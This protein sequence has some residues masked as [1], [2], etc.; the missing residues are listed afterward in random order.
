MLDLVFGVAVA[1]GFALALA[2]REFQRRLLASAPPSRP[3]ELSAVSIL[4]PLK[5][6]DENLAQNLTS[7]FNLE[8]PDYELLFGVA[9]AEDPALPIVR[10]LIEQ[11][12]DIAAEVVVDSRE[13]GINPKVNNLANL[14]RRARHDILLISDSNVVV[15]KGYLT[16]LVANLERPGVGMVSSP[17][18]GV[19]GQGL[20]GALEALQLNT[21]VMG[22][23][24][25]V[26]NFRLPC[27]VEKSMLFRRIHLRAVG[28]FEFLGQF[29]AEDQVFA[30]E[31]H[32]RQM[33]I[34]VSGVPV[35]NV[36]GPLTVLDFARRHVRWA[37]IRRRIA[38]FGYIG[39][40]L[41]NPTALALIGAA[42]SRS[43]DAFA[44]F[45]VTLAG[46]SLLDYLAERNLKV[47][48]PIHHYPYL[49][50]LRSMVVI[51][52]W[53]IPFVTRKVSWR[54]TKFRIGPRTKL[55]RSASRQVG[56]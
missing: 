12:P 15:G 35:D 43:S 34:A 17:I 20:G 24:S 32:R 48:R 28:G 49:E 45:A 1:L 36:L 47:Q 56:K 14:A 3:E 38:L 33:R 52:T 9:D 18:R 10:G 6:A 42:A 27:V 26:D 37:R 8:Y 50:L 55:L 5:G 39:E 44:L 29:L 11:Y 13:V 2:M 4:K 25:V 41:L 21:F 22:G 31:I 46:M 23:V 7:F 53:P 16:D 54:G 30:E 40:L 19:E 51:V